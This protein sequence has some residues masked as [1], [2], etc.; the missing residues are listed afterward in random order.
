M[1]A[2]HIILIVLACLGAVGV[3]EFITFGAF[4]I[5]CISRD[6]ERVRAE[7]DRAICAELEAMITDAENA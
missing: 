5:W 2:L 6:E 7:V 3:A 1:T 4:I